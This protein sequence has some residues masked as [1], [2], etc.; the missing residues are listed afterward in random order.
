MALHGTCT[1]PT[2]GHKYTSRRALQKHMRQMHEN[3][4]PQTHTGSSHTLEHEMALARSL[5]DSSN[6][7]Q[8]AMSD[9]LPARLHRRGDG[10]EVYTSPTA[11][12]E[13]CST[14]VSLGSTI[15]TSIEDNRSRRH[16]VPIN[17]EGG[18]E[19]ASILLEE[20]FNFEYYMQFLRWGSSQNSTSYSVPQLVS[21]RFLQALETGDSLSTARQQ[22]LLNN[23]RSMG[24]QAMMMPE[25]IRQHWDFVSQQHAI[26]SEDRGLRCT[27]FNV[28]L[29][30]QSLLGQNP[31]SKISFSCENIV[32][33][34]IR[35]LVLN[36]FN[37]KGNLQFHY[38]ESLVYD[39][40][41]TGDRWKRV[42][43]DLSAGKFALF[44]TLFIDSLIQDKGGFVSAKGCV[45]TLANYRWYLRGA[46]CCKAGI[47]TFP[48]V[49]VPK[50][51]AQKRIVT[52]W[53][54]Q[55]FHDCIAFM[56]LPVHEFNHRGGAF[57]QLNG[58][59]YDIQ[60]MILLA[61]VTD[62]PEGRDLGGTISA[63]H[64]C[65]CPK[66]EQGDVTASYPARTTGNMSQ[67]SAHYRA[68][69][70]ARKKGTVVIARQEA[71]KL[72]ISVDLRNGFET[73]SWCKH[74]L[75]GPNPIYDHVHGALPQ[76]MLHGLH[77][78]T[79][80]YSVK[81]IIMV[82]VAS[83]IRRDVHKLCDGKWNSK[84]D[85]KDPRLG[86]RK[87]VLDYVD[88][89]LRNFYLSN[90]RC[91]DVEL[92][93]VGLWDYF[94]KDV[95]E[96]LVGFKT[97]RLNGMCYWSMMRQVHLAL[98]A[99]EYL[100]RDEK[101]RVSGMCQLGYEV[102]EIVHNPVKK[103]GNDAEDFQVK[104]TEYV[105]QLIVLWKPFSKSNCESIKWHLVHHWLWYLRQMGT[106]SDE[107]TLEKELGILFKKPYKLTNH[108][109][110]YND[111]MANRTQ[112]KQQLQEL[113]AHAGI[114]DTLLQSWS[115]LTAKKAM[116]MPEEGPS[117]VGDT[118]VLER[119]SYVQEANHPD[120]EYPECQEILQELLCSRKLP[121]PVVLGS[122]MKLT[123][124]NRCVPDNEN[125]AGVGR[126]RPVTFRAKTKFHGSSWYDVMRIY[127]EWGDTA[128]VSSLG[129]G[130]CVCF[131]RDANGQYYAMLRWYDF[132][133]EPVQTKR[134]ANPSLKKP[135]E[136]LDPLLQMVPLHLQPVKNADSYVLAEVR[137]IINGGLI[138][139]DPLEQGKYWA[140]QGVRELRA[141]LNANGQ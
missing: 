128:V 45:L 100:T 131:L 19:S 115:G 83:A 13:D 74:V 104:V 72:G 50:A 20:D 87:Y 79:I 56:L 134:R 1:C 8:H 44:F 4:S 6:I 108:R 107:R 38:E 75:F 140:V 90:A 138:L 112:Q 27:H 111:Q 68:V 126:L 71:I 2:C 129:Y 9:P 53:K 76:G 11:A 132:Y 70:A 136:I 113:C 34:V 36:P 26:I 120:F 124:P 65:F 99:S 49:L 130:R 33:V 106:F 89:T 66:Q 73:P 7:L 31:P 119:L 57:V 133:Q 59:G 24:G 118:T 141:F 122:A 51:N 5:S 96:G 42:M 121:F 28:P 86:N 41:C 80:K 43:D 32:L 92:E 84:S 35:L 116:S 91:S 78:G 54:K 81:T 139:E 63:C 48:D 137:S 21:L 85:K 14:M 110:D 69:I 117:L 15:V 29:E 77:E 98:C 125:N 46:S 55:L 93:S 105:K 97:K 12:N 30:V 62:A 16:D 23:A 64:H 39:D 61:L 127:Y 10:N 94:P 60:R 114:G 82:A 58:D 17:E 25:G 101:I 135:M 18:S 47:C 88:D 52:Q 3:L 109:D 37:E 40:F 103:D 95:T 102:I 67:K 123:L 22:T